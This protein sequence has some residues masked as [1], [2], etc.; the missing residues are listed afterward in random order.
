MLVPGTATFK[1]PWYNYIDQSSI[2]LPFRF[3]FYLVATEL[4]T[5][6]RAG[7]PY[8]PVTPGLVILSDWLNGINCGV[9]IHGN[10]R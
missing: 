1:Q 9:K 5:V 7:I 4:F 6:L 10:N 8:R 3:V 2:F